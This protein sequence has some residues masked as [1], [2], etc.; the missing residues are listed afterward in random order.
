MYKYTKS[1]TQQLPTIQE[2]TDIVL[3]PKN[4]PALRIFGQ[5]RELKLKLKL[6]QCQE[7]QKF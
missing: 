2:E 1:V 7:K 5:I 4:T 6:Q 3:K